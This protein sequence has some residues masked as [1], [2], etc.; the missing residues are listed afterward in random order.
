MPARPMARRILHT[1]FTEDNVETFRLWDWL[2]P[3]IFVPLRGRAWARHIPN[4]LTYSRLVLGLPAVLWLV[5]VESS[6]AGPL[7]AA[8]ALLC[9][10]LLRLTDIFDGRAARELGTVSHWG[11]RMDPVADG[12]LGFGLAAAA[13]YVLPGMTNAA[14]GALLITYFVVR[15]VLDTAVVVLRSQESRRAIMPLP[16][17]WGKLK[18]NLDYALLLLVHAGVLV[19]P[20]APWLLLCVLA[21]GI[22]LAPLNIWFGVKNYST[23]RARLLHAVAVPH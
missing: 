19:H 4:T 12:I 21:V 7:A 10:V 8:S 14:V 17:K 9:L 23:H 22:V 6:P 20:H 5:L 16:T 1:V 13:I 2:F 3:N 15:F 11:S 18:Y